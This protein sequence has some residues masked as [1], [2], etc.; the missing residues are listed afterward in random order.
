[1]KEFKKNQNVDMNRKE[2]ERRYEEEILRQKNRNNPYNKE[3]WTE[4]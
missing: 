4:Y 1:M 3:H 2:K